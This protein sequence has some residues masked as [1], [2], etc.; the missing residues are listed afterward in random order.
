MA[1]KFAIDKKDKDIN[2]NLFSK[3]EKT[4]YNRYIKVSTKKVPAK[5]G[6][7]KVENNL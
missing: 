1:I 3:F 4:R 7:R 6:S 5:F 2:K